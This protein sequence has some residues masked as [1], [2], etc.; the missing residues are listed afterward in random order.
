MSDILR[1]RNARDEAF[2]RS[3]ELYARRKPCILDQGKAYMGEKWF[4]GPSVAGLVTILGKLQNNNDTDV[5][6]ICLIVDITITIITN[7]N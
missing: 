1:K 2:K 7:M 3:A 6:L 4:V 5:I